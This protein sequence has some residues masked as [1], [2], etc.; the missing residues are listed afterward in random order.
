MHDLIGEEDGRLE[1]EPGRLSD[2][3]KRQGMEK[4]ADAQ[5]N[6]HRCLYTVDVDRFFS[7]ALGY[8][9]DAYVDRIPQDPLLL[10]SFA[11][12][13]SVSLVCTLSGPVEAL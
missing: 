11:P 2:G 3:D 8:D 9:N 4:G 7:H 13:T 5:V 12:S 1:V 10:R 6:F